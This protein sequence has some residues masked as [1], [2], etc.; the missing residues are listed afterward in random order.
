MITQNSIVHSMLWAAYGDALGFIAE[1]CDERTLRSRMRGLDYLK[2]LVKWRRKIGG[3]YGVF[4]ELPAGCYSDGTQLRLA[5]CRGVRKDGAFDV[6]S[7][8]KIELPIF[9]SYR[10]GVGVGTKMAAKSLRKKNI[11]WN[12]NFFETPLSRYIDGRGSGAAQRIQPHV[13]A[14]APGASEAEIIRE[15]TRDAL[16]THGHPI[17]WAGAVFHGLALRDALLRGKCPGPDRWGEILEKTRAIAE[18]CRKDERLGRAWAPAWEKSAGRELERG[19]EEAVVEIGADLEKVRRVLGGG[20]AGS[21]SHQANPGQKYM[22]AVAAIDGFNPEKGGSGAKTALLA[23][24]IAHLFSASPEQGIEVCANAFGS[25]A[26]AIGTMAGALLGVHAGSPPPQ[27]TIDYDYMVEQARRLHDIS[28]G[29]STS[30]F[31]Y[32][33]LRHWSMPRS[34]LDAAGLFQ[35]KMALRGLG[36]LEPRG[37][38]TIQKSGDSRICWRFFKTAFG[39][40]LLLKHRDDLSTITLKDLPRIQ[41]DVDHA[42]TSG[43]KVKKGAGSGV[44]GPPPV[45]SAPERENG[46]MKSA[47]V[48]QTMDEITDQVIKG[49]FDEADIGR[50]LLGFAGEESG[51]EKA[52]SFAS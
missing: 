16:I 1:P 43:E 47:P 5:V 29:K 11:R 26:D 30:Q 31:A 15:I 3:P 35:N 28:L 46:E 36:V 52:I 22:D 21:P 10:L 49:G 37:A 27:E 14:A 7:F 41:R 6:D 50:R 40:T 38:T 2:W 42:R 25:Q 23:S 19:V 39:Q 18:V 48:V 17:A 8:S 20:G 34:P 33:N 9:L 12:A 32:P 44:A 13:L 24:C 4:I 51:I 45:D